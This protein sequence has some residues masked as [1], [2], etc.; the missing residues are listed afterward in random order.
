MNTSN[1]YIGLMSGTS[2]DGIDCALVD[3]SNGQNQVI[4]THSHALPNALREDI[5]TLCQ[6]TDVGLSLLGQTDIAIGKLFAEATNALLK[7]ESLSPDAIQAIGSHGQTIFHQPEVEH[8]FTLQIGD[9][10]TIAELTGIPTVADLRSRDMVVKGQGAPLAPLL[11]Q[12]CFSSAAKNRAVINIGGMANITILS[13]KRPALAYDTGPGN[14]LMDYW[15]NKILNKSFDESGAWSASGSVNDT[16][17]ESMLQDSYFAQAAPKSTGRELFNKEWL[18]QHLQKL[19]GQ[20]SDVDIM[21]TLLEFTAVSISNELEK[22]SEINEAF[23]CGGGVHN[24]TLVNRVKQLQPE[25]ALS[26]TEELGL[27]PDWVEAVAFAWLAKQ[28][29]ENKKLDTSLFTGAEKPVI[30]GA[31]YK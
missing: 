6:G 18:A 30:L 2:V 13:N 1:L 11:H 9:A 3:F 29:I 4:A 26:N 12:H 15:I 7:S 23:L 24:K 8:R 25:I 17:L 5:L 14:V 19:D 31:L 21:A 22:Y 28:N 20:A 27:H 16:L 10:N